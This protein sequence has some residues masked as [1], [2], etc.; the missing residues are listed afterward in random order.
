M[1]STA[2]NTFTI[3][4]ATNPGAYVSGGTATKLAQFFFD[5]VEGVVAGDAGKLIETVGGTYENVT[6]VAVD[7]STQSIGFASVTSTAFTVANKAKFELLPQTPSYQT[8]RVNSFVDVK[9]RTGDTVALA[10]V[11]DPQ[12]VENWEINYMNNLEE[13]YGSLRKSPSVIGE[14]GAKATIKYEKYFENVADRDAYRNQIK[15]AMVC[16]ISN[17]EIVSATDTTQ[18]KYTI[19]FEFSDIRFTSYEMP[20]G[21]DELYVLAI[22]ATAFYDNTDGRALRIKVKNQNAGT[23][24]TA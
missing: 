16:T 14:K 20:T 21:T 19:T 8:S 15:S 22:E 6:V 13:R 23:Y 11:A 1:L 5:N 3:A 4:V 7:V 2:T 24:Y 17:N 9:F 12:N 10:N 18:G